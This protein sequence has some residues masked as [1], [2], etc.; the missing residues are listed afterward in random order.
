MK[1]LL[2]ALKLLT[3]SSR[4]SSEA[5]VWRPVCSRGAAGLIP[6]EEQT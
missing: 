4:V 1:G 3:L 6:Q 5:F 2:P